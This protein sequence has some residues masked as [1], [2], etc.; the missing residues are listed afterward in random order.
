M[1]LAISSSTESRDILLGLARYPVRKYLV[2]L[3]LAGLPYTLAT[4]DLGSAFLEHRS[5]A[6]LSMGAVGAFLCSVAARYVRR[7]VSSRSSAP[8]A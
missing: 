8:S 6:I 3:M 5:G 2:A 7:A 1:P 4:V